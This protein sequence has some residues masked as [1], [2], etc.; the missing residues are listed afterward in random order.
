MDTLRINDRKPVEDHVENWDDDDFLIDADDLALRNPNATSAFYPH[1][2]RRDSTL[3]QLS[4]R[5]ERESVHAEEDKQIHLPDNGE[6]STLNAIA[7]AARAGIPIPRD[8]PPSAL[9]GTIKR[10]GGRKVKKILQEDWSDDLMFPEG[11]NALRIKVQDPERFP[12]VLRQLSSTHPSPSNPAEPF[13]V[14]P[15]QT[16]P[17]KT[18]ARV[19]APPINLDRFRDTEEADD[20]FG[21]GTETI[22]VSKTR[23]VSKPVLPKIAT[24]KTPDP[25]EGEDDFEQDLEIPTNGTLKLS[26]RRDI[27][28]TPLSSNDDFDWG[29][30]S[31]GTRYGGTRRDGRSNRSS[32][33]SAFSPSI[34]SSITI[35]S[36]D[37]AQLD[38]IELP[39]GPL[40]LMERL[41]KQCRNRSPERPIAEE[42][43]L[44][45]KPDSPQGEGADFFDDL[46]IGDG[47]V[48]GSGQLKL[49]T[50]VTRR[51]NETTSPARP[52]TAVSLTFTNKP[53][54][55]SSRLPRP[56]H[57]HHE[58]TLTQTS[59]EPVSESGGP[60]ASRPSR[61]S[62][63]RLGHMSQSSQSSTASNSTP[64]TPSGPNFPAPSTPR[65]RE[66]G[67]KSSS[68]SLRTEATTTNA[69]LLR[70]KRSL[71]VMR[72]AVSPARGATVRP[73][74]R[75]DPAARPQSQFRPKTPVD[76][77]RASVGE[78]LAA[79]ARKPFL[80]AAGSSAVSSSNVNARRNR[81]LRRQDSDLSSDMR[82]TSRAVS[83]SMARS[84]SPSKR[85]RTENLTR[86]AFRQPLSLPKRPR[87]FG[88]GY[89][90]EAFDDLPTSAKTESEFV[91]QPKSMNHA[92]YPNQFRN[93]VMHQL[94]PG[95]TTS[96]APSSPHS[97]LHSQARLD[98]LPRFA[99]DTASSRIA[100][101]TNL[102]HRVPSSGPLA[103]LT[104]Q[105]VAQLST[106][107]NLHPLHPPQGTIR[108]KKLPRKPPQLKPHLIANLNPT[109]ESKM[110]NGMLYNPETYRWEGNDHALNGFDAPAS[111]PSTTSLPPLFALRDKENAT[112]RPA[113]IT[114]ISSTKGV[115][116]VGGMV[117]DPQNMCWL[118]L[119]P[120]SAQSEITDPMEG[121]NAFDDED[122]VFKDIPDLEDNT[123]DTTETGRVSDIKDDWLVGEEFDVG[124][125]FIR[126]QREEEDRWRKKCERWLGMGNR[127]QDDWRWTI[128]G[129]VNEAV[130]Q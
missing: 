124:P 59:L 62:H 99:R 9:Q 126:R 45:V 129:V 121:L 15:G 16:Q 74:S 106:R 19:L 36:E 93:K 114:N 30:G 111:S 85:K 13:L 97:T 90:L 1:S 2:V 89:E 83:R 70:L 69:Q 110:V 25:K 107:S 67:L 64:I 96:P 102:A 105:R 26:S 117:F 14:V 23:Q 37:E 91:K 80:P 123:A 101:E 79:Q 94:L 49:P 77:A 41:R 55:N 5:S 8:V 34:S 113:L 12:D 119:G 88:D 38:G 116:V 51:D 32:S 43:M 65:K 92:Q 81:S 127:D 27:P 100:R 6:H 7:I 60:I 21:D 130:D 76:R 122:D 42:P 46:D 40:D 109:K 35:E 66:V 104:S 68:V 71:P 22:K 61:R 48:F 120:Q 78:S 10:L 50:N 52:K 108:S 72:P 63:S 112:P 56:A 53:A 75:T 20:L 33:A 115:Q 128:R 31:L 47:S 11:A 118:K 3:S 18:P 39:N 4:M 73:P 29:E 84:P 86:A 57:P 58:R 98:N 28:K 44:P 95:G 87:L 103:P 24:V 17:S 54:P 125:E 82:P